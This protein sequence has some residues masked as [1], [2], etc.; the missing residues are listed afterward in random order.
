MGETT[1]PNLYED[2]TKSLF[3]Q[4][5]IHNLRHY[6]KKVK[7][8]QKKGRYKHTL[9]VILQGQRLAKYYKVDRYKTYVACLFHDYAKNIGLE[10]MISL[11]KEHNL[12]PEDPKDWNKGLLH[13]TA[14]RILIKQHFGIEDEDILNAVDNHTTGRANMSLLEKIVFVADY[15]D[16]YRPIPNKE[17][18]FQQSLE[19]IDKAVFHISREKIEFILYKKAYF[20]PKSLETYNFYQEQIGNRS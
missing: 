16:P 12:L 19:N 8:L 13:S 7:M 18:F 6:H 4:Q 9:G 11:C 1:V 10:N 20:S 15:I 2:N 5:Q 17:W 3:S 14:S